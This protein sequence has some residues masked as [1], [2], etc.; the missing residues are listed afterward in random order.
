MRYHKKNLCVIAIFSTIALILNINIIHNMFIGTIFTGI[1]IITLGSWLG[2]TLPLYVTRARTFFGTI[3]VLCIIIILNVAIYYPYQITLLTSTIITII[4]LFLFFIRTKQLPISQDEPPFLER[5]YVLHIF[6]FTILEAI[7]LGTII[8]QQTTEVLPSPWMTIDKPFFILYAITTALLLYIL[9]KRNTITSTILSCIHLFVTSS[10][11]PIIYKLGYGFDG[12]IHRATETWIAQNGFILPKSPF[13]IG[14]YSFV[15]WLHHMTGLSI[16]IIDIYFVPILTAISLPIMIAYTLKHSFKL[17]S[18]ISRALIWLFPVIYFLALHLTTP[19]N[20]VLLLMILTIFALY[21]YI[22]KNLPAIIP[23]MMSIVAVLTH[24]LL[25]VPLLAVTIA[26]IISQKIT[27]KTYHI[28]WIILVY[29]GLAILPATMFIAYLM[30]NGYTLPAFENPFLHINNFLVLFK[31]PDWYIQH[32]PFFWELL[33][34]W[35]RAI[36]IIIVLLGLC[37]FV[38]YKNKKPQSYIFPIAMLGFWTAAW[39]LKTWIIFPNVIAAEQNGYPLRLMT[40]GLIFIIPFSMYGVYYL[41]NVIIKKINIIPRP[42]WRIIFILG[43]AF[44]LMVSLYFSYP[45]RNAKVRFGGFNV[46]HYDIEAVKW[47]H[48]D[49]ITD[50]YVVLANSI[51][52]VAAL[53]QYSFYKHF[54]TPDGQLF[55]YSIPTGGPLYDQI[56]QKMLYHGQHRADMIQAMNLTKTNK[57][58]FVVNWYWHNFDNI[59]SGAKKS[60]NS[61]QIISAQGGSASGG[62]DKIYIFT[63]LR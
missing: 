59:I 4:P 15:T 53:S 36:G 45:Q 24:P 42:T 8:S 1:Y 32:A 30:I 54:D 46:T 20:V 10:I 40:A 11:A 38:V 21:S 13:Y 37:G 16:N 25:G 23:F 3:L 7:L 18:G 33:Y 55:Y 61:W 34:L 41:G 39:L 28:I 5:S 17:K 9:I 19:H 29:I 50:D 57:A 47:I 52:S 58:Y 43:S 22:T 49:N 44:I 62:D 48:N 60:A 51:T 12:F 6:L 14:Q 35:Q 2:K 26:I 63:Y 56:Y 31:Q 27:K